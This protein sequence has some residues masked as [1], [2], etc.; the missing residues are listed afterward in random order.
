M[1]Q[2]IQYFNGNT[3]DIRKYVKEQTGS[4]FAEKIKP[5]ND[6]LMNRQDSHSL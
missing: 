6:I 1:I 5:Y 3:E 2:I 4:N